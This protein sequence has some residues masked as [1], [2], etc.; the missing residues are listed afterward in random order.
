MKLIVIQELARV[1]RNAFTEKM[2]ET[3]LLPEF[4][5]LFWG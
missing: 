1:V 3:A 2:V 4:V 5:S